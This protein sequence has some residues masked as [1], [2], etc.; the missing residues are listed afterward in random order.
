M[1]RL[2]WTTFWHTVHPCITANLPL[3]EAAHDHS[4]VGRNQLLPSH[5]YCVSDELVI[6]LWQSFMLAHSASASS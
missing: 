5:L 1:A 6:I 3:L 2:I 4:Q